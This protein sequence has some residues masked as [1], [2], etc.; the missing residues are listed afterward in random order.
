M[1][2]YDCFFFLLILLS[3]NLQDAKLEALGNLCRLHLKKKLKKCF[4]VNIKYSYLVINYLQSN[5]GCI[6]H[7]PTNIGNDYCYISTQCIANLI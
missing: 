2:F 6:F 7:T 5:F 1:P 3:S 4:F